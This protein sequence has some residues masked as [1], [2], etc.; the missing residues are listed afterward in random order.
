MYRRSPWFEMYF[1][2][3]N[4]GTK[5]RKRFTN[6]DEGVLMEGRLK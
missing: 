3:Q 4:P 2:A 6:K 1:P 5:E